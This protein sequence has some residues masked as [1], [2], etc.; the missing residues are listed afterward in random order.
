MSEDISDSRRLLIRAAVSVP[1]VMLAGESKS[2]IFAAL[3]GLVVRIVGRKLLKKI[4]KKGS[5]KLLTND[6]KVKSRSAKTKVKSKAYKKKH[7]NKKNTVDYIDKVDK[8]LDV[9]DIAE[10][11]TSWGQS[12]DNVTSVVLSNPT[13]NDIKADSL[14]IDAL[15]K[16]NQ[17][18]V[19]V[20]F[21]EMTIPKHTT[22]V[23]EIEYEYLPYGQ[24]TLKLGVG[25]ASSL[26][27]NIIVRDKSS[28]ALKKNITRKKMSLKEGMPADGTATRLLKEL[29]SEK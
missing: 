14:K 3:P 1:L 20:R 5:R 8:F 26:L 15:D 12:T 11:V 29:L 16:N 2:F 25:T 4:F 17:N 24:H 10:T 18:E 9:L 6:L 23:Y 19:R 28:L 7:A 13:S 21:P 22:V 27:K